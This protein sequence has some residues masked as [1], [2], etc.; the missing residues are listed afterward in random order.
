[1]FRQGFVD[2]LVEKKS[3]LDILT[4]LTTSKYHL[5][6]QSEVPFSLYPKSK[7]SKG[8]LEASDCQL[9]YPFYVKVHDSNFSEVL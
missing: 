4:L 1:M 2:N 5:V 3:L 6:T 7:L 8:G 9:T